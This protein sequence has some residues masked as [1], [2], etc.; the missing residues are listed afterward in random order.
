MDLRALANRRPLAALL[1]AAALVLLFASDSFAAAVQTKQG[2]AHAFTAATHVATSASA[3]ATPAL[4]RPILVASARPLQVVT[5]PN[6]SSQQQQQQQ[7]LIAALSQVQQQEQRRA[8]AE[9]AAAASEKPSTRFVDVGDVVGASTS[10]EQQQQ[11]PNNADAL[12][13]AA[14]A[15]LLSAND[16]A[17]ASPLEGVETMAM[18][19]RMPRQQAQPAFVLSSSA[20][21]A[22]PASLVAAAT[23]QQ[24]Q[25]QQGQQPMMMVVRMPEKH[26]HVEQQLSFGGPA[27][28]SSA[29]ATKAKSAA[30]APSAAS[31]SDAAASEMIAAAVVQALSASSASPSFSPAAAAA[32]KA[33]SS[34]LPPL[35]SKPGYSS[36]DPGPVPQPAPRSAEPKWM[37]ASKHLAAE[38]SAAA[39]AANKSPL[40]LLL[41]GDGT[42]ESFNETKLGAAS[43]YAKGARAVFEKWYGGGKLR[44]AAVLALDGDQSMNV[45]WRLTTTPARASTDGGQQLAPWVA[46]SGSS[47]SSSSLAP[48]AVLLLA[49]AEDL[50]A[51]CGTSDGRFP[52]DPA[53]EDTFPYLED[54]AWGTVDRMV[55]FPLVSRRVG[56]EREEEEKRWNFFPVF[57]PPPALSLALA[58]P[59]SNTKIFLFPSPFPFQIK[60][61][62]RPPRRDQAL[63]ARHPRRRRGLT[64]AGQENS[65]PEF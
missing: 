7:Q 65:L 40:D 31:A 32:T 44:K 46:K 51:A 19:T 24:Q 59:S 62:D 25:Q 28:S 16:D 53:V 41:V 60:N 26:G 45:A 36:C 57:F 14:A 10:A 64:P 63:S 61:L 52:G 54:A 3:N 22:L 35:L 6:P 58:L 23:E 33:E 18:T 20:A 1:L 47:S 13:S 12:F 2:G 27:P 38:V 11:Q 4:G 39:A 37:A 42:F 17:A 9:A 34:S 8:P 29:A 21:N 56:Q 15:Q 43:T 48:S 30:G 49:G 50:V 5:G 55:R